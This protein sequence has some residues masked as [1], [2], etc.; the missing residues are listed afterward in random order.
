MSHRH[1]RRTARLSVL[2]LA[3]ALLA[4]CGI[5]P[6]SAPRDVPVE[7]RSLTPAGDPALE[8]TDGASRVY[9]LAPGEPRL[10]RSVRREA[11]NVRSLV[12]T[13]IAGP[14]E[15]ESALQ[16]TSAVP[17]DLVIGSARQ[18][19]AVLYLDV[20]GDLTDL[21]GDGLMLAV[22]QVVVTA[23]DVEG[24]DTVQITV[25]GERFPLPRADGTTTTG[26]LRIYDYWRLIASSQPAYP[27]LTRSG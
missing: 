21:S 10:L 27:A 14:T 2:A 9:L 20:S 23:D 19:G 5:P 15:G 1:T 22:A 13:L 4:A 26:L 7:D 25:D 17:G 16:I 8:A 11:D 12:E 3:S 24:I 18:V 6:D